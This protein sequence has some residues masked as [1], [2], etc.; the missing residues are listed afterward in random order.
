M[1]LNRLDVVKDLALCEDIDHSWDIP[2]P[3]NSVHPF[4]KTQVSEELF[5]DTKNLISSHFISS[6]F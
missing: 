1:P 5:G 3:L 4:S 2:S 6:F